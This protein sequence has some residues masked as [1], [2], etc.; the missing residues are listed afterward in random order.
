[1]T[2]SR[3]GWPVRSVSQFRS[4][5]PNAVYPTEHSHLSP[6]PLIHMSHPQGVKRTRPLCSILSS[7]KRENPGRGRCRFV[8]TFEQ[9][10]AD[11]ER[12]ALAAAK[13]AAALGA[14]TKQLQKAALNGDLAGIRKAADRLGTMVDAVRQEAANAR[15]SWP[16]TPE[17]EEAYLSTEYKDELLRAGETQGLRLFQRDG[18]LVAYPSIIRISPGERAVRVDRRRVT[19]LRPSKH[20]AVLKLNQAKKPKFASDRFL[21]T[22]YRA[23]RLVAGKDGIGGT[24][25]LSDV[26]DALTLLP[27]SASDYD[28]TD[29]AR[30]L[31]LLDQGGPFQT[32]SGATV[33]IIAPSTAAKGSRNVLTFVSPDGDPK[34]YYGVR[35]TLN[36]APGG[37]I[38][39]GGEI[40]TQGSRGGT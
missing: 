18:H 25:T 7:R 20:I 35:F 8:V 6:F 29:F 13:A 27:A 30:D 33:S 40:G 38:G 14:A 24:I 11:V 4:F 37:Q 12:A 2:R 17:Q 1:M 16:L 3:G 31:F 9:G 10:F 22:L 5:P 26:Y 34:L 23:Y 32:K 19:S 21:E 15:T 36:T 39:M 28:R